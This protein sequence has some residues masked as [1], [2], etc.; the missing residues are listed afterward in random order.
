MKL[1]NSSFIFAGVNIRNFNDYLLVFDELHE[2]AFQISKLG[3]FK[4]S[5]FFDLD[6]KVVIGNTGSTNLLS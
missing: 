4:S 1:H 2:K 5:S 6:Y 3:Q